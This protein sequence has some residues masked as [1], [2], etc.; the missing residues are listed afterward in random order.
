MVSRQPGHFIVS[1]GVTGRI[2]CRRKKAYPDAV[3]NNLSSCDA[4]VFL[5]M[6]AMRKHILSESCQRSIICQR[7]GPFLHENYAIEKFFGRNE[8]VALPFSASVKQDAS[9]PATNCFQS[10]IV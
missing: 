6:R 4:Q 10:Q 2:I 8:H 5:A 9:Q 1:V 3:K 7:V